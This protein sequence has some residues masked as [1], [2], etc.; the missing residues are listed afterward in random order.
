[1]GTVQFVNGAILFVG[2]LMAMDPACCCESEPCTDCTVAQPDAVGSATACEGFYDDTYGW[3]GFSPVGGDGFCE[4]NW[5]SRPIITVEMSLYI[6]H[7]PISEEWEASFA[8]KFHN[9]AG[10]IDYYGCDRQSITGVSCNKETGHLEGA[11]SLL[12]C[13]CPCTLEV[14]LGG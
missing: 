9:L 10:G 4:W 7:N 6:Y 2:G 5:Y 13:D 1:M 11:F 8:G 3:V 12:L 14:T